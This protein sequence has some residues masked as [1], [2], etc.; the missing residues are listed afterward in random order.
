MQKKIY[1]EQTIKIL[2][3][4]KIQSCTVLPHCLPEFQSF[5]DYLGC[6]LRW[7]RALACFGGSLTPF[8]V[9]S[10]HPPLLRPIW[11]EP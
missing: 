6:L 11:G 1:D 8:V 9:I 5:S 7:S 10:S 3:E 4:D 2:N